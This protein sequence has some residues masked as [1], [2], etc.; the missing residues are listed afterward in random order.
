MSGVGGNPGAEV[1][2]ARRG[3]MFEQV[4]Q[5]LC[6]DRCLEW[7]CG[8]N[9]TGDHRE[10]TLDRGRETA[11]AVVHERIEASDGLVESLDRH[12][13]RTFAPGAVVVERDDLCHASNHSPGV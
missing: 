12:R 3:G 8:P 6:P 4:G 13:E 9:V 1:E 2:S 5:S 10:L 7:T 11:R